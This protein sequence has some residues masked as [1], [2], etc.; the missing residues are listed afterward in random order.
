MKK[1]VGANYARSTNSDIYIYDISNKR[2]T[3]I[4]TGMMGYDNYP[5]YSP[6]GKYIAFQSQERNGFES[7]RIRLMIYDRTTKRITEIS[8]NFDQ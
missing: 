4:T 2:T 3:N 1:I 6:D 5:L 7:D 8:Q